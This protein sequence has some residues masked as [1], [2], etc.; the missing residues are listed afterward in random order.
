M[1]SWNRLKRE[2]H[3]CSVLFVCFYL[4]VGPQAHGESNAN[5]H[6]FPAAQVAKDSIDFDNRGFLIHGKRTFIVSAGMEYARVPRELWRDRLLRLKRGGFNAVEI[7]TFWNFHEP[8]EGQFNFSGDHDLNAFLKLVRQMDMYAIVRVGPYYC[9]EWNMGGYPLWLRSK[10]GLLVRQPNALF[11]TYVDQYF[12]K[13]IPIVAA[14]Q[15]NHGGAVIL[16]QLENEHPQG[17]GT[18]LPNSYFTHLRDKALSLGI[19]VPYFFS[20]LHHANDPAGDATSLDD[21][22]RPNPWFSTEFWSVWYDHYGPQP[23]DATV[24]GRRAWKM[25]AHGGNGYNVYMAHGGSNFGYTNDNEDAASYDYGAAVGQAG[26]LRP[27]YYSFKEA[28]WFARSFQNILENS[29]DATPGLP[30]K[31]SNPLVKLTARHSVSGGVLFLDNPTSSPQDTD[32]E[33]T[34]DA[35]MKQAHFLLAPSE[36]VPVISHAPLTSDVTMDWAASR[37]LGIASAGKTTTLVLYGPEGSTAEVDFATKQPSS[38]LAGAGSFHSTPQGLRLGLTFRDGE[39][40]EYSF[41]TGFELIRILAVNKTHADSTWFV[42]SGDSTYVVSGPPYVVDV[43]FEA[44][45]LRLTL[46]HP[47]QTNDSSLNVVAYGAATTPLRFAAAMPNVDHLASLKTGTWQTASASLFAASDYNDSSWKLSTNPQQMGADGNVSPDAWYRTVVNVTRPGKQ[48]LHVE[49]GGD[50]STLYIDGVRR[51][52][53]DSHTPSFLLALTPGKH[54]IAIFTAHDGRNKLYNYLGSLAETDTKGLD[55]T[56]VLWDDA[57]IQLPRWRMAIAGGSVD[58]RNPP[59]PGSTK[60]QDYSS[61]DDVFED[62]PGVAWFQTTI[63][64][65]SGYHQFLEFPGANQD[66]TVYLNG[67]LASRHPRWGEPFSLKLDS[68]L[69]GGSPVT[70]TLLVR[71]HDGRG[72]VDK[73]VQLVGY[74]DEQAVK[75]WRTHG[76]TGDVELSDW[77]ALGV[78]QRFPGPKFFRTTFDAPPLSTLGAHPIWRVIMMGMGHGSVWVNGHNLGR[79]PEKIPVSGLYI[80]ECWL[81]AKNTLVIYDEDGRSPQDV[82]IH[83]ELAA[84]RDVLQYVAK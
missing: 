71:N 59:L 35:S 51:E 63:S 42:G 32:L 23:T 2:L 7:Y 80:P 84:S 44:G 70:V 65:L 11:E 48:L 47:W 81:S 31:V 1:P 67:Q 27:L 19:E 73:G 83:S 56:A 17:W 10:P 46:E 8:E 29:V 72:G 66:V 26:D 57:S 52:E 21:P 18:V 16:V 68:A 20:G 5:D 38:P 45:K 39:P 34:G 82:T 53:V 15:I 43:R 33:F 3:H 77:H 41:K 40:T 14:N 54:S 13:L 6:I 76:G 55:G 78:E 28:A 58:E 62:K 64:R 30:A 49:R 61:G 4:F 74:T 79:Y 36:I 37:I 9:A 12:D 24:F 50:R 75:G 69:D 60:W 22:D 25:I